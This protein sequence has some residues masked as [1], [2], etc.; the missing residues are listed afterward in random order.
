[1]IKVRFC[2]VNE[3]PGDWTSEHVILHVCATPNCC[4]SYDDAVERVLYLIQKVGLSSV[5]VPALNKWRSVQDTMAHIAFLTNF[6][7]LM[8]QAEQKINTRQNSSPDDVEAEPNEDSHSRQRRAWAKRGGEW[9]QCRSTRAIQCA[10]LLLIQ[11]CMHL[12]YILFK[13]K[14]PRAGMS[15]KA[16][17]ARDQQSGLLLRLAGQKSPARQALKTLTSYLFSTDGW[18]LHREP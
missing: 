18:K 5:G 9:L 2:C 10:F 14:M 12:H 8:Q 4:A 6:H 11:P 15:K 7:N 1:M 17:T 13:C 16:E 3:G